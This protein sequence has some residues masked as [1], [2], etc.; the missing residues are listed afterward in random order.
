MCLIVSNLA[1]E[2]CVTKAAFVQCWC[3]I[4]SDE[5]KIFWFRELQSSIKIS[6]CAIFGLAM[7]KN[8]KLVS[9][10]LKNLF[11]L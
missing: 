10:F 8:E 5:K 11:V 3:A 2:I 7:A 1:C 6:A 9:D 4:W